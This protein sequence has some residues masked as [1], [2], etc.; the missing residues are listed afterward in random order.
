M[1]H[2]VEDNDTIPPEVLA[3]GYETRDINV[4]VIWAWTLSTVAVVAIAYVLLDGM[5]T[6][7]LRQL[8]S[9]REMT[10]NMSGFD[11]RNGERAVLANYGHVSDAN[12]DRIRIPIAAAMAK[13][14]EDDAAARQ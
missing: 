10:V 14:A 7:K 3:E 11:R 2:Q 4:V 12:G 13:V 9:E 8:K 5:Y 6:A 1:S